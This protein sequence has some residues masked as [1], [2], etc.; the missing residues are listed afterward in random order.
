[1]F[2]ASLLMPPFRCLALGK[3]EINFLINLS[4]IAFFTLQRPRA[5]AVAERLWLDPDT[6]DLDSVRFRLDDMRCRMVQR[7]LPAAPIL[8]GYCGDYDWDLN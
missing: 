4:F 3:S 6:F 7:G 2:G 1:M 5:S 8:N